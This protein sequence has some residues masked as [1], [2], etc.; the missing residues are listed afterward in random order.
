VETFSITAKFSAADDLGTGGPEAAIPLI[1][2]VGPQLAALE[3][4]V[5]PPKTPGGAIGA[6]IDAIGAALS[7]AGEKGATRPTPRERLPRILFLWGTSR[8]LPVSITS[9]AITE[10]KYDRLLN[11]VQAEVQIGLEVASRPPD[12][13]EIARGA[14]NYSQMIKDTQ[15]SLNLTKAVEFVREFTIDIVPF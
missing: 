7:E 11:P 15:A 6:A 14:L 9:M 8:V 10:Q 4:M 12:E 3:K 13:D 5:Y 1:F 2:G